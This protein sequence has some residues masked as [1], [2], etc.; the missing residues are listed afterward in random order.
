MPWQSARHGTLHA[1][2]AG[3]SRGSVPGG[4]RTGG[5][6]ARA[7]SP[8]ACH[9]SANRLD[10]IARST[11]S[12]PGRH[13]ALSLSPFCPPPSARVCRACSP[14]ATARTPCP[15]RPCRHARWCDPRTGL[16]LT[17]TACRRI[18]VHDHAVAVHQGPCLT[19]QEVCGLRLRRRRR[20]L[21][22][23]PSPCAARVG[24]RAARLAR[25]K[26]GAAQ[27]TRRGAQRRQ[28]AEARSPSTAS[29]RGFPNDPGPVPDRR[30]PGSVWR[31]AG[32]TRSLH[33]DS[34]WRRDALCA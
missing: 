31:G 18:A 14:P 23:R 7:R 20:S 5:A 10:L 4:D 19:A 15:Y 30:R 2:G 29:R 26:R 27:R 33:T 21:G 6:A 11:P 8:D 34:L 16:S 1:C 9:T 17:R 24:L 22:H 25:S 28:R 32:V 13:T 3:R 12:P